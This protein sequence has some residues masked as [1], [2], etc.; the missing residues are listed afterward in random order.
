MRWFSGYRGTARCNGRLTQSARLGSLRLPMQGTIGG[1]L[2]IRNDPA[3]FRDAD[4]HSIRPSPGP[5]T[6]DSLCRSRQPASLRRCPGPT[7][8]SGAGLGRHRSR[9]ASAADPDGATRLHTPRCLRIHSNADANS[10]NGAIPF[11]RTDGPPF[12][13]P[14]R[15]ACWPAWPRTEGWGRSCRG[16]KWQRERTS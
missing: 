2:P 10:A 6:G 16:H 5:R 14:R 9:G 15:R 7:Q 1:V 4:L 12:G 13:D 8:G 11:R 3:S